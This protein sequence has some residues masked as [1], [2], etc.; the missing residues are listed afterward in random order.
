MESAAAGGH[1]PAPVWDTDSAGTGLPTLAMAPTP[2][3]LLNTLLM[4]CKLV[5]QY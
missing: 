2:R 4:G 1:E 3:E 5:Q